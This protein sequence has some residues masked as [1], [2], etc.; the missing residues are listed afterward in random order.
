MISC[1]ESFSTE[2]TYEIFD[3]LSSYDVFHSFIHL[4]HRF[5]DMIQFYPLRIDFRR[6]SRMKFDFICHY[7]HS[8]QVIS[9]IFSD[10][11]IPEQVLL[12]HRYFPQFQREFVHLHSIKFIETEDILTD[13]P[14][15]V[16]ALTFQN[17]DS[18]ANKSIIHVIT[19]QAKY[20]TYRVG[21]KF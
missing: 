5:N 3:Y 16:T 6:I 21:Q 18:F 2:V 17:C 15:S 12:F 11:N 14:E 19:Q 13:L 7:L 1:F 10:Q 20:L 8:K 4:N 9:L